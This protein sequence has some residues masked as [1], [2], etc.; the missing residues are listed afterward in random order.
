MTK[1]TETVPYSVMAK[2]VVWSI[3]DGYGDLKAD[4]G[5][6]ENGGEIG[7]DEQLNWWE[8]FKRTGQLLMPSH[9]MLDPKLR[10]D[11]MDSDSDLDPLSYIKVT[12]Q[13]RKYI[14]GL[15][16]VQQ[17]ANAN[18]LGEDNK[19]Q[20]MFFPVLLSATLGLMATSEKMIVDELVM[21]LPVKAEKDRDRHNL[22]KELV[23]NKTHETIIELADGTI[24]NRQV[25]VNSLSIKSQPFG[26]FCSVLFDETGNYK[27]PHLVSQ[28]T[29]IADLGTKTFNVCTLDKNFKILEQLTDNTNNGMME[30]YRR[31]NEDI[32]TELGNPIPEGKL[33]EIV[34]LG[35]VDTFDLTESKKFHY[36]L[37]AQFVSTELNKI[38]ANSMAMV[39]NIIWTGG[40]T[41][42]TREWLP[43]KM[44]ARLAKKKVYYLDRFATARGLRY[45]GVMK[46]R[47]A[48]E[49]AVV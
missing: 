26:S 44:D 38:L 39:E 35:K 46:A 36:E 23:L 19:H 21:G 4:N 17:D 41:E 27:N 24:L 28:V 47:V 14:V 10:D 37:Q 9:I 22:L 16:A 48:Q 33:S 45:F 7:A 32:E 6:K 11:A 3:D 18:W 31:I 13:K 2:P 1:T 15:G 20:H 49:A 34:K 8:F 30:A 25:V 12:Y 42:V 5:V 43:K 40:G 29:T